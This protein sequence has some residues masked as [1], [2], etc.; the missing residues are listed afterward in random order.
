MKRPESSQATITFSVGTFYTRKVHS[1]LYDASP[2]QETRH[3]HQVDPRPL[4]ILIQDDVLHNAFHVNLRELVSLLHLEDPDHWVERV[5]KPVQQPYGLRQLEKCLIE[6]C[7]WMPATHD[8][9]S[10]IHVAEERTFHLWVH[11]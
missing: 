3:H 10:L 9:V 8:V 5:G 11:K 1:R 7:P 6:R 4:G 2:D